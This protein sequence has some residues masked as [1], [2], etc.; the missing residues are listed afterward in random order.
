VI[1][2]IHGATFAARFFFALLFADAFVATGAGPGGPFH[3]IVILEAMIVM[4]VLA[5]L[6]LT[7]AKD[8]IGLQH[9]DQALSDPLTGV[10][11]RRAFEAEANRILLR[12]ARDRSTTALILLDLDHFKSINDTWGHAVGDRALQS[13]AATV[14]A[15]LRGGDVLGRLGGEEF[16][17]ALAGNRM[18]QAAV[19]AE[20][21]RRAVSGKPILAAETSINLTV[22]IGVAAVRGAATL[23][24]LLAHADAALYRAKATGRNRVEL[25]AVP[26]VEA[27]GGS[28]PIL[29]AESRAA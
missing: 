11:N 6:L 23:D 4:V 27:E 19:L 25:A 2:V 28:P 20:R 18:D 1:L 21:I 15:Q 3:P 12:A 16:A 9:R 7:A 14:A 17:V 22:S 26:T 13:F 29:A 24:S 8:E 5:F 10:P